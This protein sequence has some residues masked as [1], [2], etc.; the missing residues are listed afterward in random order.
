MVEYLFDHLMKQP[1]LLHKPKLLYVLC[2]EGKHVQVHDSREH[3]LIV[4]ECQP[5]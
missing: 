4:L 3:L 5:P 2:V 1:S